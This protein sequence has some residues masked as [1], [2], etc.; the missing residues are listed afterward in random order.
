[1]AIPFLFPLVTGNSGLN[2]LGSKQTG[3]REEGDEMEK[4]DFHDSDFYEDSQWGVFQNRTVSCS[5]VW[6]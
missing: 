2:R 5:F 4:Y 3:T 6:F 1:V